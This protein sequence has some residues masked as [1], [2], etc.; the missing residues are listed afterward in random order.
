VVPVPKPPT[1]DH[2]EGDEPR[3]DA[4]LPGG[5]SGAYGDRGV[6]GSASP[7]IAAVPG[8]DDGRDPRLPL[9][10]CGAAGD[11]GPL[12]AWTVMMVDDVSGP[13]RRCPGA[14]D[15]ELDGLLGRWAAI[16]SWAGAAKLAV[17]RE[18]IRRGAGPG[19]GPEGPGGLPETWAEDL[20]HQV[21]PLLGISLRAA[22]KLIA[23]AWTLEARLPGIGH[24]LETGLLDYG[25]AKMIADETRVL[26]DE[27]AAEAEKLIL[28]EDLKGKTWGQVQKIAAYA[29]VT[30][31]PDGARKR[32][33]RA[34][35]E[36]ARVRFWRETAGTCALAAY[37]L[38]PD[39]A[40]A[41]NAGI[42][43]R[44]QD[45]RAAG[46]KVGIDLLRVMAF[47]DLINGIPAEDRITREQEKAAREAA[48]T[49]KTA[50][51]DED[52]TGADGAP[53]ES[54]AGNAP[55]DDPPADNAPAGT[56]HDDRPGDGEPGDDGPGSGG[57][58]SGG[59]GPDRGK[60]GRGLG[61]GAALP[62]RSN[63]TITLT[64]LLGLADRA[65]EAHALGPLDPALARDLAA[66]AARSPHSQ[67]CVTVTDPNGYAIGHGCARI[68]RA[69]RTKRAKASPGTGTSSRDGPWAF[70]PD[71]ATPGPPGGYGTWVLTLPGGQELTVKLGP[72]PV[73][74]CDHRYELH[75]YQPSDLL[76]HLVQIRDGECTF[77][78][79][80]RHARESDFEHALPYDKGGRT[81]ACNAGARSRRCH[82]I[83]QSKGWD[84]TQPLPGWHRWTTPSGRSYTQGPKK[85]PA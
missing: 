38:P 14:T 64:D 20:A 23:L 5:S 69:K 82:K 17:V 28:A 47:A 50:A 48:D 46:V 56:G 73:T 53:D 71:S 30:V 2:G 79:C 74:K 19:S 84:V 9:F 78:S 66:A 55:T 34:Q 61:G 58:D 7:D 44:A 76:R 6:G 13:E 35:Q 40:L 81:C 67:W 41:A 25:K 15:D 57:P 43:Q 60:P 62:A 33:E 1:P 24:A 8:D 22:D 18:L 4:G 59:S 26:D 16:E 37:G 45:Y 39:E 80:S 54:P 70:T 49:A 68:R 36:D 3:R 65:G 72:V 11:A 63:L 10:A 52:E 75:S 27:Q 29:V 51:R 12:N 77:P 85:Y 83:K 21:A 31:D 32:R 42:E